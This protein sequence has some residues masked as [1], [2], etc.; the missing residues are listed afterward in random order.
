MWVP[1]R[2]PAV[3]MCAPYQYDDGRESLLA[4]ASR[5]VSGGDSGLAKYRGSHRARPAVADCDVNHQQ[6]LGRDLGLRRGCY[7]HRVAFLVP[8]LHR[9]NQMPIRSLFPETDDLHRKDRSSSTGIR[10]VRQSRRGGVGGASLKCSRTL[11]HQLSVSRCASM[12]CFP[13]TLHTQS[14][15]ANGR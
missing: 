3:N 12:A 8:E 10:A 5:S 15:N 6:A 13:D 11:F 7:L 4:T 14:K 9:S 1:L 2:R